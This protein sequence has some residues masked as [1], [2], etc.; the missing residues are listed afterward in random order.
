MFEQSVVAQGTDTRRSAVTL[1]VSIGLHVVA[2]TSALFAAV[3]H[4]D[5]PSA[6]P[7]QF[8]QF[9]NAPMIKIPAANPQ[10]PK[11]PQAQAAPPR[12]ARVDVP[13]TVIPQNIPQLD[14]PPSTPSDIPA[15]PTS[16]AV[17]AGSDV[18][19]LSGVG[20]PGGAG[21]D[22]V[23]V[24]EPPRWVGA[25]VKAPI[26]ITRVE[27]VYPPLALK[28]HLDGLVIVTATIDRFGNVI[29]AKILH[30]TNQLF[31]RSALDAVQRWKFKAGTYH[32]QAID[33]I[34]NLTVSF[35][36]TR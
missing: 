11:Q 26:V 25:D 24:G 27:P 35:K 4:V 22:P 9:H 3:W 34:F 18:P 8:E 30:S 1:P 20:G 12:V 23:A 16:T 17:G 32:G 14:A 31:E 15:D 13:P 33:T 19:G 5:F 2:I 28:M 10:Q 29:D 36:V 21:D 6:S 7:D